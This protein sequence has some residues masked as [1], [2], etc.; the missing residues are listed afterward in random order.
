L[1]ISIVCK[2]VV[3]SLKVIAIYILIYNASLVCLV[4]VMAR[5][6]QREFV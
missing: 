3:L 2:L 1:C 6:M 4:R 5:R